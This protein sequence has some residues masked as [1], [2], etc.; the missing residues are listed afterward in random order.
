MTPSRREIEGR[1]GDLETEPHGC[2][3]A[4]VGQLWKDYLLEEDD[5]RRE[6]TNEEIDAQWEAIRNCP[7]CETASGTRQ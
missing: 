2:T 5:P 4:T 7:H 6:R 3:H 1:I